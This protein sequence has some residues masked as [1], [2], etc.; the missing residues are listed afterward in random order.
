MARVEPATDETTLSIVESND[1]AGIAA[2]YAVM[3]ELR[4]G[5]DHGAY[6]SRVSAAMGQGYRLARAEQANGTTARVVGVI[7]YRLWNDLVFGR[8]LFVDD[9]VVTAAL[10]GGGVG[11][12]LLRFAEAVARDEGCVALRLNSGLWREEAHRFYDGFGLSKRGFAFT[13]SLNE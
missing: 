8:A 6:E 10:R 9:L 3:Q 1:P 2:C 13:K 4:E 12:A 7:G 11:G 5:L